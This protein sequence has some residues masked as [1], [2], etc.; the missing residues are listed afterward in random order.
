MPNGS[1]VWNQPKKNLQ[2]I[3]EHWFNG[4]QPDYSEELKRKAAALNIQGM[5]EPEPPPPSHC[6]VWPEHREA[7]QLFLRIDDQWRTNGDRYTGID[8]N[9]AIQVA[10]IYRVRNLPQVLEDLRVITVHAVEIMNKGEDG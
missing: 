10:R 8:L 3:A 7:A 1:K 6:L 2:G 9:V 5:P 4:E